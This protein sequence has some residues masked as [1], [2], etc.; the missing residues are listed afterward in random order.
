MRVALI[1]LAL[2]APAHAAHTGIVR[3]NGYGWSDVAI[4]VIV[5]GGLLL[6]QAAMRRRARRAERERRD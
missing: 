3:R 5:A 1:L 2:S 6:A 4:F